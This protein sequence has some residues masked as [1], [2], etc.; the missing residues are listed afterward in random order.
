MQTNNHKIA[1]YDLVLDKKFGKAGTPERALAEEK[2]YSFYSGQIL[3]DARKEANMT[4]AELAKRTHTTKSY[5]SK[6]ENGIITPS[7]GAFYRIISALG[8][9][10]EIVKPVC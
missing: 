4:Q 10:V 1:D 5:I 6:I 3:H 8:M 9:R 7:V 2:A